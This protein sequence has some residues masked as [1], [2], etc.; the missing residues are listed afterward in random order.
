MTMLMPII[1]KT[2]IAN[3]AFP[4][5][6]CRSGIYSNLGS[7]AVNSCE[8]REEKEKKK[9]I[10]WVS[11][12]PIPDANEGQKLGNKVPEYASALGIR[13]KHAFQRRIVQEKVTEESYM[14]L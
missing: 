3:H 13:D 10:K 5:P 11:Y 1:Q 2:A 4:K 6:V 7:E 9:K 12:R 8:R 14:M